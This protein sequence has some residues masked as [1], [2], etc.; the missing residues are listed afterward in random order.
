[1]EAAKPSQLSQINRIV[2]FLG[3]GDSGIMFATCVYPG[4]IREISEII[5]ERTRREDIP[6][7]N[8]H[9]ELDSE[10]TLAGQIEVYAQEKDIVAVVV[11]GLSGFLDHNGDQHLISLNFARESLLALGKPILIWTTKKRL[12]LIM[13]QAADL[14]SQ[15]TYSTVFFEGVPQNNNDFDPIPSDLEALAK[16]D[17]RSLELRINLLESQREEAIKRNIKLEKRLRDYDLPLIEAY[18]KLGR[19]KEAID[20]LDRL[21]EYSEKEI[22]PLTRVVFWRMRGD[23]WR[24][25]WKLEEAKNAYNQAL[26]IGLELETQTDQA[27][28]EIAGTYNNL[29][30]LFSAQAEFEK[31]KEQYE[32]SLSLWRKLAKKNPEAYQAMVPFALNNIGVMYANYSQNKAAYLSFEEAAEIQRILAQ[33]NPAKHAGN[34]AFSLSNLGAISISLNRL[35]KAK[36]YLNQALELERRLAKE[37]PD[38]H[39]GILTKV[40]ANLGNLLRTLNEFGLAHAHL[41][42]SLAIYRRITPQNPG[43]F[44]PGMAKSLHYLGFLY[45]DEN[46]LDKAESKC[47]EALEIYKKLGTG[48]FLIE[49]ISLQNTISNLY[50]SQGNPEAAL[51]NLT[52]ALTLVKGLKIN[53]SSLF[54]PELALI[55]LNLA[56]LLHWDLHDTSDARTHLQACLDECSPF[57]E[58]SQEAKNYL[59]EANELLSEILKLRKG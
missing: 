25:M 33:Q 26:T 43:A 48:N 17:Q 29:G 4:L 7:G 49:T 27:M 19:N 15:R 23:T 47:L 5:R 42:E 54:F 32:H 13:N 14:Y 58:T 16:N 2:R 56:K 39:L 22:S 52:S 46:Q 51:A 38:E 10:L 57:V 35:D 59:K 28:L 6:V 37:N 53:N 9:L 36:T 8:L 50:R 55:E 21:E 30:L 3:Q 31:G 12:T 44:L 34:L 1:M 11:F 45:A 41:E 18:R 40:L 24:D 20:L